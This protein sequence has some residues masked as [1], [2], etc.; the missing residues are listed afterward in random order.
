[1]HADVTLRCG[2]DAGE[3]QCRGSA[4][5]GRCAGYWQE[6]DAVPE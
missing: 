2:P 5:S 1:V 6:A 4:T 3:R